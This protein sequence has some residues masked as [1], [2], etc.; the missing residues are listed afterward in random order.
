[1]YKLDRNGRD[2]SCPTKTNITQKDFHVPD[3]QK[4]NTT[5]DATKE[6]LAKLKVGTCAEPIRSYNL[7]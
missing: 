3:G 7:K 2:P 5:T 1:M 6:R 4:W